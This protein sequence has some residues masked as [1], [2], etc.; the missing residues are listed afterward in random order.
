M[1]S[2]Q[3]QSP[4]ANVCS[5]PLHLFGLQQATWLPFNPSTAFDTELSHWATT[6]KLRLSPSLEFPLDVV[7]KMLAKRMRSI[8]HAGD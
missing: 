2:A 8:L 1:R 4:I 3:W 6:W 5:A 7:C